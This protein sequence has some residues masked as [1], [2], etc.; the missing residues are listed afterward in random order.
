MTEPARR[1]STLILRLAPA[2]AGVIAFIVY[3]ITLHPSIPGG[4]SGELIAVAHAPGI[5]H[6]P[7]YP[8][9]TV[10]GFLW[11]HIVPA[12]SIAWRMNLLSAYAAPWR[13]RS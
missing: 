13:S 6:P 11:S 4:D 7:G 10:I 8:L 3:A 9:Y 12:G 1:D 2:F 5:A